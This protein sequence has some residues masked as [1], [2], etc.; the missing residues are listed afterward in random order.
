MTTMYNRRTIE[1]W[2]QFNAAK[3][4]DLARRRRNRVIAMIALAVVVCVVLVQLL[5]R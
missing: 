4:A 1:T 2:A 3:R 5:G